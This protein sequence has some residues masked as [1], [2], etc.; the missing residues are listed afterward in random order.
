VLER[1]GRE[2]SDELL[3][4][5]P[6]LKRVGSHVSLKSGERSGLRRKGTER[7]RV[8]GDVAAKIEAEEGVKAVAARRRGSS[9]ASTMLPGSSPSIQ[10]RGT[11]GSAHDGSTPGSPPSPTLHRHP[12][13]PHKSSPRIPVFTDE[14][15]TLDLP[16]SAHSNSNSA[17]TSTAAGYPFPP[18]QPPSPHSTLRRRPSHVEEPPTSPGASSLSPS[19]TSP[20]SPTMK[21]RGRSPSVA[22]SMGPSIAEDVDGEE[23]ISQAEALRNELLEEE[24]Q[25]HEKRV[26]REE[27]RKK[28]EERDKSGG[29]LARMLMSNEDEGE[30]EGRV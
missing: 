13:S 2:T 27:A 12:L 16:P 17:S 11:G 24:R 14:P 22:V 5:K 1:P 28:N 6:S 10:R 9:G 20:R 30:P 25:E 26:A 21:R 8:A 15:E 3:M 29:W 18:P 19:F 23:S 4:P 7:I